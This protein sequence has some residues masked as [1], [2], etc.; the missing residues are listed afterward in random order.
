MAE[1]AVNRL[2]DFTA[3]MRAAGSTLPGPDTAAKPVEPPP[4]AAVEPTPAPPTSTPSADV[5][6]A[7]APEAPPAQFTIDRAKLVRD[8]KWLDDV[9]KV[10]LAEKL[11]KSPEWIDEQIRKAKDR[12]RQEQKRR[13]AEEALAKRVPEAVA[14][15]DR[16]WHEQLSAN[17]L[18]YD[19]TTQKFVPLQPS[20]PTAGDAQSAL[21]EA[22]KKAME[23]NTPEA[24]DAYVS[25][26]VT[27][28]SKPIDQAVVQREI[29]ARFAAERRKAE[30][31][32][33]RRKSTASFNE[34]VKATFD[35]AK[36]EFDAAGPLADHYRQ[37]AADRAFAH[38]SQPGAT[39][40]STLNVIRDTATLARKTIEAAKLQVASAAAPAQR[41]KAPTV[42]PSGGAPA[43]SKTDPASFDLT[44]KEG[45]KAAAKHLED[46]YA[47]K[48]GRPFVPSR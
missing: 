25:A 16:Q 18:R 44:T 32:D 34:R 33:A 10:D 6:A 14:A 45:K 21:A 36:A 19:P 42:I 47:Q 8:I 9:E 46:L 4:A 11:E 3:K 2:A 13:D 30:E 26:A 29:D 5:P 23:E 27:A 22:R 38:S 15:R 20:A 1:A 40:E 35:A 43:P 48:H 12:D 17:G 24:W 31:E 39:E 28:T 7:A 41:V 37:V